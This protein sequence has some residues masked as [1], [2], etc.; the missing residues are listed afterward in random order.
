VS[1]FLPGAAGQC[2]LV[3]TRRAP[4]KFKEDSVQVSLAQETWYI[5][6]TGESGLENT[7]HR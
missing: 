4:L 3:N 6:C 2:D 1:L 7:L 5:H